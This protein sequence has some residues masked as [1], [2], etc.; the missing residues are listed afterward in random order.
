MRMIELLGRT[1]IGS[2][3]R[4]RFTQL[5]RSEMRS[6]SEWQTKDRSEFGTKKR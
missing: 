3:Q 1:E 4:N 6:E 5:M 2:I